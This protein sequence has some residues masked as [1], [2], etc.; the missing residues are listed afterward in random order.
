MSQVPVP[1]KN[2]YVVNRSAIKTV[3]GNL[4]LILIEVYKANGDFSVFLVFLLF[5]YVTNFEAGTP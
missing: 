4:F 2:S 5:Y 1:L 3:L